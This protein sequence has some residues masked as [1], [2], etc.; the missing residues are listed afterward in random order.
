M[1]AHRVNL[2]KPSEDGP[3]MAGDPLRLDVEAVQG[4]HQV[5]ST[6]VVDFTGVQG[7]RYAVFNMVGDAPVQSPSFVLSLGAGISL[8]N[9]TLGTFAIFMTQS[10]T[11][12][13]SGRD[14]HVAKMID[15]QGQ[16]FSLFDGIII[17]TRGLE[18]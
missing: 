13:W 1:V 2:G 4:S 3:L 5:G 7:I 9:P 8:T 11:A 10:H 6:G 12:L 18:F 17:S 14:W 15:V 16:P